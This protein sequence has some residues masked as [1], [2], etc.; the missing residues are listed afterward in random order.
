MVSHYYYS[1][2]LGRW[3][4]GRKVLGVLVPVGTLGGRPAP[5]GGSSGRTWLQRTRDARAARTRIEIPGC[6]ATGLLCDRHAVRL[7]TRRNPEPDSYALWS[8]IPDALRRRRMRDAA[9]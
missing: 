1:N 8:I 7:T 5:I 2:V 6:C 9:P 4:R 3:V